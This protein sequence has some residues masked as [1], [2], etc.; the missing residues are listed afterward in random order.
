M[1]RITSRMVIAAITTAVAASAAVG[2][3]LRRSTSLTSYP[4]FELDDRRAPPQPCFLGT[5]NCLS[6]GET[7]PAPCLVSTERC[8]AEGH[9]EFVDIAL[10]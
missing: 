1:Q 4:T 6:R 5:R 9:V 3:Q 8:P 10:R 7:P 2:P